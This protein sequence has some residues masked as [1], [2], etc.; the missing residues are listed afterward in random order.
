MLEEADT[1][2][3]WKDCTREEKI[4][5]WEQ[6]IRVLKSLTPHQ[7]KRHFDMSVWMHKTPCG[8]VACAAG[9]CSMDQW[10]ID[11]GF[12]GVLRPRDLIDWPLLDPKQFFG[13]A[14]YWRIFVG[15]SWLSVSGV[16]RATET[17][18]NLMKKGYYLD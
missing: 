17:F 5:R 14:G 12:Q 4:E 6:V 18:V 11:R 2:K 8:T 15:P 3:E 1:Y 10:F 9:H 13:E 7:R 16:I